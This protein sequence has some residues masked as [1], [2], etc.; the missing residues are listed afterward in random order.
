MY[1]MKIIT[2]DNNRVLVKDDGDEVSVNDGDT[3][4]YTGIYYKTVKD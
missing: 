3:I 2:V 4:Q 1:T